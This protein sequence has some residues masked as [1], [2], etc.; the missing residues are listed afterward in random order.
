MKKWGLGLEGE[1]KNKI[2]GG[3]GKKSLTH[4]IWDVIGYL[5]LYKRRDRIVLSLPM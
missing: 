3:I 2:H 1:G 5:I 4:L